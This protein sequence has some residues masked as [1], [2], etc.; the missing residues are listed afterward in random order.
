MPRIIDISQT[1]SSEITNWPGDTEYETF[2]KMQLADGD[3]CNVGSITMSL[4]TG[5]HADAP[6]HFLSEGDS[7]ADVDLARY[8]GLATVI[9]ATGAESIS[10]SHIRNVNLRAARILFKTGTARSD[11][12]DDN[13]CYFEVSRRVSVFLIAVPNMSRNPIHA[14][15]S[16]LNEVNT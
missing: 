1:L 4:H 2:W 8:L 9:D 14:T 16:Q 5:T 6:F 11:G 15:E 7:I 13:F 10:P 12:F 3:S